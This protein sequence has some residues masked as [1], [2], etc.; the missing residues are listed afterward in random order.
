MKMVLEERGIS[1]TGKNASW[2][3]ETLA[4]HPD[5]QDEKCLVAHLVNK[6]HIIPMFL[7]KFHPEL[8]P[9]ERV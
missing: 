1:T 3:R 5:F 9:I 7:P 6:G 8:N 4:T 2:M